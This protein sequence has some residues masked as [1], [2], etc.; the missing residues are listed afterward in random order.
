MAAKLSGIQG[1]RPLFQKAYGSP[2]ITIDAVAKAIATFERTLP[3][4]NRGDKDRF[5]PPAELCGK[6]NPERTAQ[7]ACAN[8]VKKRKVRV[9]LRCAR[10][11]LLRL[12]LV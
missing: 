1:Y 10:L 3:S 9:L 5:A 11:N 8:S 12:R 7:G 6:W 4:G 2:D